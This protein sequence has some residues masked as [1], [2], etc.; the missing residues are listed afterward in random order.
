MLTVGEIYKTIN[1]FAPFA[2]QETWDNSG[3]LVGDMDMPAERIVTALDIS[4]EVLREA[5]QFGAQLIVAHHPVIFSP[6][7][8]LPSGHPVYQLAAKG[9][10]AICVHT[11]LDIAPDGLNAYAYRLLKERLGLTG[12]M[13]VLEPSWTDGRGFGWVDDSRAEW[14]AEALAKALQS[15]FGCGAVRYSRTE[16]KLRRIAYCSGSGGSMLEQAAAMGCDALITGDVKHDRWYAAS[17]ADIA[18][19]DCGHF[20]TEQ[21]AAKILQQRLQEAY[22]AAAVL[23]LPGNPPARVLTT[24]GIQ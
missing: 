16:Q 1:Q 4:R 23:C 18:L 6:L 5:E 19:F 13:M 22:P 20:E 11:P 2:S 24:G 15:A 12:E 8:A 9:I 3:L 14:S 21:M 10:A 17:Y 7:K